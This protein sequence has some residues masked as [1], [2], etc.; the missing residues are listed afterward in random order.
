MFKSRDLSLKYTAL[1]AK[2]IIYANMI[3]ELSDCLK[4]WSLFYLTIGEFACG[5]L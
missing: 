4:R 5:K 3:Y 2:R 1:K